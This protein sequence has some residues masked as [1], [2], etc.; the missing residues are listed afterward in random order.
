MAWRWLSSF[1][2][3]WSDGRWVT[4]A[5]FC[6]SGVL[7]PGQGRGESWVSPK[8][9]LPSCQA[10]VPAGVGAPLPSWGAPC[11]RPAVPAASPRLTPAACPATAPSAPGSCRQRAEPASG[12]AAPRPWAEAGACTALPRGEGRRGRTKPRGAGQR[13]CPSPGSLSPARAAA[14]ALP[15]WGPKGEQG[16]HDVAMPPALLAGVL[17]APCP[18]SARG[19]EAIP[20]MAWA[21]SGTFPAQP[22]HVAPPVTRRWPRR[23]RWW[24]P[25]CREERRAVSWRWLLGVPLGRASEQ[26][27]GAQDAG[28]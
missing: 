21:G 14:F 17:P 23:S 18:G 10:A 26:A 20:A 3:S 24:C 7:C 9:P 13:R 11:P 22:W 15:C 27:G 6:P 25:I 2:R 5:L 4:W 8:P 19:A 28:R 12:P 16:M 1:C